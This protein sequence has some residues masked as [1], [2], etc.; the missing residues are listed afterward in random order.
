MSWACSFIQHLR[1]K[2]KKCEFYF[3][4]KKRFMNWVLF[5]RF[6]VA[7]SFEDYKFH[8]Q[9]QPFWLRV[10]ILLFI[11]ILVNFQGFFHTLT[12]RHFIWQEILSQLIL[13]SITSFAPLTLFQLG[14][15]T[16]YPTIYN[17]IRWFAGTNNSSTKPSSKFQCSKYYFFF[18]IS[19][20]I[21]CKSHSS[22]RP[23]EPAYYIEDCRMSGISSQSVQNILIWHVT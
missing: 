20:K 5:F 17:I 16:W 8:Y 11:H 10:S 23:S 4:L 3:F 22:H 12:S 13:A 6:L 15:V 18:I 21:L 2:T 9:N 19:C 7:C 14:F 1:V